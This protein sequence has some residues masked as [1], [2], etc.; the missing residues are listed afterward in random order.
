MAFG[1]DPGQARVKAPCYLSKVYLYVAFYKQHGVTL[2]KQNGV[3][4]TSSMLLSQA[5]YEY[6][7]PAHLKLVYFLDVEIKRRRKGGL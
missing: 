6:G 3:T 2:H 1:R 5:A 7:H 4:F